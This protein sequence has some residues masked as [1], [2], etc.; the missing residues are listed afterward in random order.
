M[1]RANERNTP[2]VYFRD[3]SARS[4]STPSTVESFETENKSWS[5][6]LEEA[7]AFAAG[8]CGMILASRATDLVCNFE[9]S[10]AREVVLLAVV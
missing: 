1:R 10:H 8:S 9:G 3:C 4:V 2:F 7:D 6:L 5:S